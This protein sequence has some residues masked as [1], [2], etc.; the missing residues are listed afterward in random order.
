MKFILSPSKTFKSQKTTIKAS[1][2]HGH[3]L[4]QPLLASLKACNPKQLQTLFSISE[5]LANKLFDELQSPTYH[6]AIFY[7]FGEAFKFL[8]VSDMTHQHIHYLQEHSYIYSTLYGLLKPLDKIQS[9]RLDFLTP[10]EQLGF[11]DAPSIIKHEVTQHLIH[12]HHKVI[13]LICSQEF[14]DKIDLN[15]L[16]AHSLII[17][18]SFISIINGQEKIVSVHAKHARGAFLRACVHHNIVNSNSLYK[19]ESFDEWQLDKVLS[20]P[21]HRIYKKTF[22]K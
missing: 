13:V 16:K 22:I 8:H 19:L 1:R 9:Y 4:T 14:K 17:D 18:T 11:E 5:K 15:E 20:S 10:F 21:T 3:T 6:P 2:P 12:S 7:Y